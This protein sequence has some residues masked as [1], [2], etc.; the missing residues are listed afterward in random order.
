[1]DSQIRFKVFTA[2]TK[3]LNQSQYHLAT[4]NKQLQA[5]SDLPKLIR[6]EAIPMRFR[7]ETADIT[8]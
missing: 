5:P 4:F 6:E 1:M 7:D 2:T 8:L 3:S